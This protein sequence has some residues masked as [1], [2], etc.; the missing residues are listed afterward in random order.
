MPSIHFFIQ[1]TPMEQFTIPQKKDLKIL[2][3]WHFQGGGW[4][5]AVDWIISGIIFFD[6]L[7]HSN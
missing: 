3:S 1:N 4:F 2:R 7:T 6:F 5:Y